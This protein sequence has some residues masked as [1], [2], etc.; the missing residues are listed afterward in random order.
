MAGPGTGGGSGSTGGGS[1]STGGGANAT[2]GGDATGGGNATGGGSATGGGGSGDDGGTSDTTPPEVTASVPSTGSTDVAPGTNI[3]IRFSEAMNAASVNVVAAPALNLGTPAWDSTRTDLSLAPPTPFTGSTAYT[4]TITGTDVAGNA[5]ATSTISFST[6]ATADVTPPTVSNNQPVAATTGIADTAPIIVT[7]SEPMRTDTV[8][9]TAT[10]SV[11][12]G[13]PSFTNGDQVVTVLPTSA[14]APNTAYTISVTGRDKS[15]NAMAAPHTFSFTTGAAADL[16]PP[17]VTGTVPAASAMT[18]PTNTRISVT[19]SEP[20]ETGSVAVATTP[21]IALGAPAFSN[22]DRT[23]TYGAPS[24]DFGPSTTYAVSING[25]DLRGNLLATTDFTFTTATA[26][27]TTPPIVAG[28]TPNASAT[29]VPTNAKI[30][31][32]FSEAMDVSAT[33]AAVSFTAGGTAVPCTVSWQANNSVLTCTPSAP[34]PASTVHTVTVRGGGTPSAA[35]ATGNKLAANY[36]FSFTTGTMAD[37]TAP[38]VMATTPT[39]AAGAASPGTIGIARTTTAITVTFSE[40]MDQGTTQ[41]AF[42]LISPAAAQG[43]TSSWNAASTTLTY[44]LP[45]SYTPP[46]GTIFNF[47]V[48]ATATDLAGNALVTASSGSRYFRLRRENTLPLWV[49]GATQT[50]SILPGQPGNIY[51]PA[52][53]SGAEADPLGDLYVGDWNLPFMRDFMFRSYQT[54][55]MSP[56][57]NAAAYPNIS[58]DRAV[59]TLT[60]LFCEGTPYAQVSF[61]TALTRTMVASAIDYGPTLTAS[62]C[63]INVSG[64]HRFTAP[65]SLAPNI[66]KTSDVT[67]TFRTMWTNRAARSNRA[68]YMF[69]LT[70]DP[71]GTGPDDVQR[72]YCT[73]ASS[74][75]PNAMARPFISVTVGYD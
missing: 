4:L 33:L 14:Y 72:D 24:A 43:G 75:S 46:A 52:L 7:F 60:Q 65:Q 63:G 48:D 17:T 74:S 41:A 15:S 6:A 22:G 53:C 5:L 28:T 57:T 2:G 13:P 25:A 39:T 23:V 51:A 70:E 21:A 11:T 12:F 36:T 29:G 69:S 34:M 16:V 45:A 1:G 61:P 40:A 32:A 59:L 71:E 20:M 30:A 37:T 73:F 35:D 66:V 8:T 26:P 62:D 55:D 27:D 49:C 3:T 68:Q 31:I 47:R 19:F 18:V 10:P 44:T 50:C 42:V 54:F 58:I 64:A 9:V 38:T 56:L 67:V